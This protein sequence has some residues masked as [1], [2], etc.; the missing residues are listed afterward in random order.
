M[1]V[2]PYETNVTREHRTTGKRVA[3][4]LTNRRAKK[5]LAPHHKALE[6]GDNK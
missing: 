3:P 6:K 5:G 4:D 1:I 2:S